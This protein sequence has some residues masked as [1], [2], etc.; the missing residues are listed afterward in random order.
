MLPL[1]L[2]EEIFEAGADKFEVA[3]GA[4]GDESGDAAAVFDRELQRNVH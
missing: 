4:A 3:G 1:R 2:D